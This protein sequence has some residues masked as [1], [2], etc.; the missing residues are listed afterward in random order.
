LIRTVGSEESGRL[1]FRC[2]KNGKKRFKGLACFSLGTNTR[3]M[4]NVSRISRMV[5]WQ[6]MFDVFGD[7]ELNVECVLS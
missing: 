6:L 7:F 4:M 5:V 1:N 2:A 3:E